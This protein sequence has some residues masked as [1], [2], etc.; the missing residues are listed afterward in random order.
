MSLAGNE[1]RRGVSFEY[2]AAL[3]GAETTQRLIDQLGVVKGIDGIIDFVGAWNVLTANIAI[4]ADEGHSLAGAPVRPGNFELLMA[5]MVQG[6]NLGDG[7]GRLA[8]G[9][10]VI[11][12][13]LA[14]TVRNRRNGLRVSL[15]VRHA[16]ARASQVYAEAL[17]I[18]IHCGLRWAI[19]RRLRP[20]QA[21]GCGM[22]HGFETSL[23]DVLGLPV[24]RGSGGAALT[25]AAADQDAPFCIA[26]F[27]RW[28]E[29]GFNEYV[30][31]VDEL[32][33]MPG[34]SSLGD[35]LG[36]SVSVAVMAG[37]VSQSEV[38]RSLGMSVATLRR[39]LSN[40][41]TSFRQIRESVRRDAANLLLLT[42]KSID[43]IAAEL[44]MSDARCFRR[45][46][47]NWFGG[48]P[49]ELRRERRANQ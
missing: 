47:S 25:Y 10:T 38:A 40:E 41:Q 7:L 28:R 49:S 4:T 14:I 32:G 13:D 46:C 19:G 2:I 29:A 30:R 20:I 17:I 15:V 34:K 31:L 8:A 5:S 21:E 26:D 18:V 16:N 48:S 43:D 45:A 39:R 23:L 6:A 42:D 22:R 3:I 11:R 35:S 24:I 36:Q 37:S 12:P 9:A 44:G 1:K 33:Q 27:T